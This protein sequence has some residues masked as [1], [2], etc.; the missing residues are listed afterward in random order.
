MWKIMAVPAQATDNIYCCACF[1]R[2]LTSGIILAGVG[3][4]FIIPMLAP[5]GCGW[6]ATFWPFIFILIGIVVIVHLFRPRGRVTKREEPCHTTEESTEGF[7]DVDN[8]FG[9]VRHIVLD[10]VFE[11]ARI[12]TRFCGTILDLKR[13]ALAEGDTYVDVDMTFSGLEIHVPE[14]WAVIVD[15]VAM[16]MAGVDDKRYYP[17][18]TDTSRRL[19]IR[20]RMTLSGIE[21]K[22]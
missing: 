21:I 20:G 10:P 22:S 4:F 15:Q 2:H 9:V 1:D 17:S 11:G 3:V 12:R 5:V 19:I 7:V 14:G 6:T 18:A 13:T 16:T 8:S